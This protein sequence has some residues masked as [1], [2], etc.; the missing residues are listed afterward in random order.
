MNDELDPDEIYKPSDAHYAVKK[1]EVHIRFLKEQDMHGK[2]K[3]PAVRSSARN[4]LERALDEL[5]LR[6]AGNEEP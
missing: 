1:A 2:D 3:Y 6:P 5:D 4:W